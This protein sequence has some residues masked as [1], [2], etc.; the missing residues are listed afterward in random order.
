MLRS[1]TITDENECDRELIMLD[2]E[3]QEE[4]ERRYMTQDERDLADGKKEVE[5][6]LKA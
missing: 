4:C 5:A 1:V 6:F 3:T 2:G